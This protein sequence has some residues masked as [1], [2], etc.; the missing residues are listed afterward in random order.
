MKSCT[1]GRLSVLVTYAA[2]VEE[3]DGS[4]RDRKEREMKVNITKKEYKV[5]VDMLEIADWVL[6]SY[7]LEDDPETAEYQALGQKFLALAKD[8]GAR[9]LVD[10][11]AETG[12]YYASAVHEEK[13]RMMEFIDEYNNDV[14][15]DELA[16][17]LALRDLVRAEGEER[18]R[19]MNFDERSEKIET[20]RGAYLDEFH[21]NG[22]TRLGLLEG[23]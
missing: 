13:S 16:E 18:I 14:F 2:P 15:W 4:F 3:W 17:R 20:L 7:R 23:T 11:D 6:R 1:Q 22:I 8:M 21:A 9:N 5:L 10:F 19:A 12:R